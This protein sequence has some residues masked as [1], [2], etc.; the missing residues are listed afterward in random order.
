[1]DVSWSVIS[2][3][4]IGSRALVAIYGN[5]DKVVEGIA[6]SITQFSIAVRLH[7]DIL[8]LIGCKWFKQNIMF[9]HKH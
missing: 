4:E 5:P 2:D 1:M 9:F 7:G 8:W 3:F 6:Q